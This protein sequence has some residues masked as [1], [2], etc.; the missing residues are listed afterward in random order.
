MMNDT[1]KSQAQWGIY[2]R[3]IQPLT[4]AIQ[5]GKAS[6]FAGPLHG[7]DESEIE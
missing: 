7:E 3:R 5:A 2:T 4:R 6:S 1:V